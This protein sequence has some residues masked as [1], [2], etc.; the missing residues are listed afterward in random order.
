MQVAHFG[1]YA[2]YVARALTTTG[3]R[4]YAVVAEVVAAAHDADEAADAVTAYSSRND[5]AIG[6]S[7]RE[8]HVH[9]RSAILHLSYH[10]GKAQIG[11]RTAHQV[12]MVVLDEVVLDALCHAAQDTK[13]G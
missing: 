4:N 6:L 3:E 7:L 10:V 5:V 8:H 9:G 11:V 13:V 2:L 1:K 12:G